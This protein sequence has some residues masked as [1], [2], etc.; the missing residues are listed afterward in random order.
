MGPRWAA[1]YITENTQHF[2]VI[3]SAALP[4]PTPFLAVAGSLPQ[5]WPAWKETFLSFLGA[6]GLEQVEPRRKKQLLFSLLGVEGQRIVAAFGLTNLPATEL[7]DEFDTFMTAVEKHFV[8]SGSLALERKKLR[9][10]VQQPGESVTEYLAAQ[11]RQYDLCAFQEQSD[12]R[13]CDLFLDGLDS[14]RVQDR[15][16]RECVDTQVPTLDRAVQLALQFEQL[17]LTSQQYHQSRRAVPD[18]PNSTAP[19]QYVAVPNTERAQVTSHES[20][21]EDILL[22]LMHL[23]HR[24]DRVTCNVVTCLPRGTDRSQTPPAGFADGGPTQENIVLH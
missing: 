17:A 13:M 5:A 18:A 2:T 3:Q 1:R 6:S 8:F 7:H 21:I 12:E 19:V 22:Q 20:S 23:A 14:R 15:I 4:P 16:L 10:R 11:R 9:S 24:D